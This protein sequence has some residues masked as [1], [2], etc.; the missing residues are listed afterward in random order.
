M[1]EVK[2]VKRRM[3]VERVK[4]NTGEETLIYSARSR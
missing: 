4:E 1:E 3:M 2:G